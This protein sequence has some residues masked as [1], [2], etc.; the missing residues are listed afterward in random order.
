[1]EINMPFDSSK[2]SI[3]TVKFSALYYDKVNIICASSEDNVYFDNEILK[4]IEILERNQVVKLE[5]LDYDEINIREPQEWY[6][7]IDF[8]DIFNRYKNQ[9]GFLYNEY[10]TSINDFESKS[11]DLI[12]KI[13]IY[14]KDLNKTN[15]EMTKNLIKETYENIVL[16]NAGIKAC[17]E[18]IEIKFKLHLCYQ[19][20]LFYLMIS[21]NKSTISNELLQTTINQIYKQNNKYTNSELISDTIS[22]LLPNFYQMDFENILDLRYFAKD[23]LQEMRFYINALS[24]EFSPDDI[25]LENPKLFIENKINPAIKQLESK[26]YGL[27][28]GAVQRALQ[29]LKD[30]RTYTP[31]LT[32][33]F[34]NIPAHVSLAVSMGLIAVESG[35]E[36]LKQKKEI[37]TNPLY[38]SL[39]LRNIDKKLL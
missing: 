23:E 33:F 32:T 4:S 28:A 39:K 31:L 3:D 22:I 21:S 37:E 11:K 12:K 5:F 24:S 10:E 17:N 27:R 30:P 2:K 20:W 6:S 18:S 26:I 8:H 38:F 7:K 36:Y 1:M 19:L 9:Y 25:K 13:E 29:G 14:K 34:S 15:E 35:L 16:C